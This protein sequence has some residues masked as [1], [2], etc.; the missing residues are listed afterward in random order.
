MAFFESKIF[1]ALVAFFIGGVST[2]YIN[3]YFKLRKGESNIQSQDNSVK[4]KTSDM[5][6]SPMDTEN[7]WTSM[8]S[9]HRKMFNDMNSLF[10]R[11]FAVS[12]SLESNF[13]SEP[14]FSGSPSNLKNFENIKLKESE[15]DSF[16]YIELFIEGIKENSISVKVA[17]G[18]ISITGQ[19]KRNE[20]KPLDTGSYSS[21]FI[22]S[23]KRSFNVPSGVNEEKA[24]IDSH[25]ESIIIKL[26]K[27]NS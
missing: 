8:E 1:I 4:S 2:Y 15:D 27:L 24:E 10:D 22:S 5:I 9:F 12:N 7:L 13:L 25:G 21:T 16:K 3:D 19:L 17:N 20:E 23:F 26:P 6:K 18:M 11:K 14:F